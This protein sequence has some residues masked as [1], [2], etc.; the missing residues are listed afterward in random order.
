MDNCG[1]DLEEIAEST[2]TDG[3]RQA[4]STIGQIQFSSGKIFFSPAEFLLVP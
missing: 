1:A 4:I 2:D 3:P